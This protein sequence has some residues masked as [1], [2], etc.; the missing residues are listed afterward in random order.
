MKSK[1]VVVLPNAPRDD[2]EQT[3]LIDP[4]KRKSVMV[5]EVPRY[6]FLKRS[7]IKTRECSIWNNF[8]AN[9]SSSRTI[10]ENMHNLFK[11][12]STKSA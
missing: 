7:D 9:V 3:P 1:H 12:M 5:L 10:F 8:V 6:P 2:P 11:L 4:N